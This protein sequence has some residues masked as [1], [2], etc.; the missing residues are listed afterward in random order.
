MQIFKTLLETLHTTECSYSIPM[1]IISLR[2]FVASLEKSQ[3]LN[4]S[5][6]NQFQVPLLNFCNSLKMSE[7]DAISKFWNNN[8]VHILKNENL[9][10]L[11]HDFKG[12]TAKIDI[13]SSRLA[14]L[15]NH[16]GL[17][18][19]VSLKRNIVEGI[20][21]LYILDASDMALDDSLNLFNILRDL[22]AV[23]FIFSIFRR[24]NLFYSRC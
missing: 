24:V 10:L 11:E 14:A 18:V 16:P 20:S 6:S 7:L 21:T 15:L 13:H 22:P 12:L 19:E 9:S 3:I 1:I 5:K 23:R 17:S 8:N 2:Q 4:W